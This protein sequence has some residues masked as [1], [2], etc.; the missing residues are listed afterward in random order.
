ML[1]QHSHAK[2]QIP[3]Q[4]LHK[5][6]ATCVTTLFLHP[7]DPAEASESGE[8]C[9]FRIHPPRQVLLDLILQVEAQLIVKFCFDSPA[10]KQ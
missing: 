10:T 3:A 9:F 6:D 4:F 7:L 8:P 2:T 1:E 5:P